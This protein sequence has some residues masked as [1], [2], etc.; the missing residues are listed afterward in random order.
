MKKRDNGARRCPGFTAFLSDGRCQGN[1]S[2]ETL[3]DCVVASTAW[4]P[5][6]EP[7][8]SSLRRRL[9]YGRT[10][11]NSTVLERFRS[12]TS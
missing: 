8:T 12:S 11:L 6:L 3:I 10:T 5:G 9:I 2:N 7:A 1:A 4:H